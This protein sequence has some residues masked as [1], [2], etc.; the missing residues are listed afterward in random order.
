MST[1]AKTTLGRLTSIISTFGAALDVAV[2]VN[3]H[4]LPSPRAL[5][6][7]GIDEAEFRRIN[8]R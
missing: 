1:T 7:L 4:R 2:A 3:A 5:K 6:R 8:Y